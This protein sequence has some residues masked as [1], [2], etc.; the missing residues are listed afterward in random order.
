[1]KNEII[2]LHVLLLPLVSLLEETALFN[3]FACS[4]AREIC[5]LLL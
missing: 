5:L 3:E 2:E 1:M 4:A